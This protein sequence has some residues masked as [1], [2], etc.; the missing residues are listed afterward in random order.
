MADQRF[1]EQLGT[2]PS[3]EKNRKSFSVL[4]LLEEDKLLAKIH[5]SHQRLWFHKLSPKDL[6]MTDR[7]VPVALQNPSLTST[8]NFINFCTTVPNLPIT[9]GKQLE[10]SSCNPAPMGHIPSTQHMPAT[11]FAQPRNGDVFTADSPI[12]VAFATSNMTTGNVANSQENFLAAPQQLSSDGFVIGHYHLVVDELDSFGQGS[13]TDPTKFAFFAEV[14]AT[15][16]QSQLSLPQG[17]YRMTASVHAA[18]H[19]P[20]VVGTLIR[21]SLNDVVYVRTCYFECCIKLK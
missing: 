7:A 5:H 11:R 16:P 14:P 10:L 18:N 8:N 12:T 3:I 9:N 20:V 4:R 1:L 2:V 13:P 21:G 19:Q 15:T 17:F 6:L